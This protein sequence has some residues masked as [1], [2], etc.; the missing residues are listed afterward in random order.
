MC[1]ALNTSCEEPSAV[2][3]T[4]PP[5]KNPGLLLLFSG[6]QYSPRESGG[7]DKCQAWSQTRR[8][9]VL[10]PW[11]ISV[12]H[13]PT[14]SSS[15]GSVLEMGPRPHPRPCDSHSASEQYLREIGQSS[16]SAAW[17][18]RKKKKGGHLHVRIKFISDLLTSRQVPC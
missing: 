2:Q 8:S 9:Q 3:N 15:P 11:L 16:R 7:V 1:P 14:A 5:T 17:Q 13:G 18:G 12:V 6:A 10:V 4:G